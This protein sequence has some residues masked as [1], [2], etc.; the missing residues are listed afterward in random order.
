MAARVK[1]VR[2]PGDHPDA[3]ERDAEAE[4]FETL[5]AG[6]A[7]P[8]ID[9]NHLALAALAQNPRLA[10]KASQLSGFLLLETAW[11]RRAAVRELAMQVVNRRLG[12]DYGAATRVGPA[13]AA[14]LSEVQLAAIADWRASDLF[15]DEQRLVIEYAETAVAGPIPDEIFSRLVAHYGEQEAVE[16]TA[17]IGLWSFWATIA[18]ATRPEAAASS[19]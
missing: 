8:Q 9:D 13:K 5:F 1:L 4:L 15:D 3:A 18:N 2:R 11:G 16:C 10:L 6:K 14:G 19:A 7:D 17:V 12:C